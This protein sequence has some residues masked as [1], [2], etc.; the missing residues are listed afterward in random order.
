MHDAGASL[1]SALEEDEVRLSNPNGLA[2]VVVLIAQGGV[3]RL[4]VEDAD[5]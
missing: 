4:D 2:G 5:L 1:F 3:A